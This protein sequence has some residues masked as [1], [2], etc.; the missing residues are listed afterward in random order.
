VDGPLDPGLEIAPTDWIVKK[1]RF[2][3]FAAGGR[4]QGVTPAD[5][6][7]GPHCFA[8]RLK[9]HS[10]GALLVV[11]VA[12]ATCVS[13]SARDAMQN[14]LEVTVVSDACAP[15]ALQ[16][17]AAALGHLAINFA[18]VR[19]VE[20]VLSMIGAPTVTPRSCEAACTRI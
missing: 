16:D 11:G 15:S 12:T 2:S 6:P 5:G 4:H 13:C 14:D 20:D 8:T 7:V 9:Q 10:I 19:T 1:D 3:P 18:D 17:H